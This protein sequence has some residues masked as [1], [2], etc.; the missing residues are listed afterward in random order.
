MNTRLRIAIWKGLYVR[1]PWSRVCRHHIR[2][3]RN[4]GGF[5][6][7]R[8][9]AV[10]VFHNNKSKRPWKSNSQRNTQSWRARRAKISSLRVKPLRNASWIWL[11]TADEPRKEGSYSFWNSPR[12]ARSAR[13]HPRK[14]ALRRLNC[15]WIWRSQMATV[16][17]SI[18]VSFISS[19][20]KHFN[21]L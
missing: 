5:R 18:V 15:C 8:W 20:L 1:F 7:R 17:S 16:E 12:T 3:Y 2:S 13:S 11:C 10:T 14:E 6:Q 21:W 9:K 4:D 19:K